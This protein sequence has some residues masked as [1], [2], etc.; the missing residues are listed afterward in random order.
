MM[1]HDE[2]KDR[3]LRMEVGL[4]HIQLGMGKI[5]KL[6]DGNGQPSLNSR[7]TS[8]EVTCKSRRERDKAKIAYHVTVIGAGLAAAT[9]LILH[10]L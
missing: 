10:L 6:L 5:E 2:L 3:M 7:L 9:A 4:E 8:I 1:G